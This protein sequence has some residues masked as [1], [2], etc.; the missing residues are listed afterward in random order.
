M[1]TQSFA[2]A[3]AESPGLRRESVPASVTDR[4]GRQAQKRVCTQYAFGGK[5]SAA[6]KVGR[7]SK[8]ARD[9]APPGGSG[10][11][12]VERQCLRLTTED[13]PHSPYA[14]LGG[15]RVPCCLEVYDGRADRAT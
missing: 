15:A 10:L 14:A 3:Q 12:N 2:T 9:R 5:N 4:D 8:C 13:A 1:R 7:T 11:W 6:N